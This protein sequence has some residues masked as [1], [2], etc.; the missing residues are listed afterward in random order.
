MKGDI[1]EEYIVIATEGPIKDHCLRGFKC[2]GTVEV[3][4]VDRLPTDETLWKK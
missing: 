1:E 2:V 3:D 4:N